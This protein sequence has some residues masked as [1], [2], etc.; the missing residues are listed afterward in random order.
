[1]RASRLESIPPLDVWC[2]RHPNLPSCPADLKDVTQ[3]VWVSVDSLVACRALAEALG[4]GEEGE[5]CIAQ[6]MTVPAPGS[7]EHGH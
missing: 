6:G 7:T 4:A 5:D 2:P 3:V 1:M